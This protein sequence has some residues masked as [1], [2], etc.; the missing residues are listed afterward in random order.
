MPRD[1]ATTDP[2]ADDSIALPVAYRPSE[3]ADSSE[4]DSPHQAPAPTK[5]FSQ[6]ASQFVST[7]GVAFAIV[8]LQMGQGILLARLL[9]PVGRGEYATAVFYVQLL[10]YIG[11]FG[12]LEIICRYAAEAEL[13]TTRLRRAA[14]KLGLATGAITTIVAIVFCLVALPADK[15][16]LIPLA[17]LCSLSLAGQQVMLIM[18]AVDRGLGRFGTYN[19]RRVIAAA[20]FPVLLLVAQL[21]WGVTLE[22]ACGLFVIASL[23]SMGAC[24]VGLE[25]PFT[26]ESG[27]PVGKL[28]RESLPYALSMLATDLF[29][30]L[31][32]LLVLWIA[33]FQD[34]GFYAAMVPAVYPLTVLPNTMGIFLFNAAADR[35]RRLTTKDVHRILGSSIAVQTICTIVFLLLIGELVNLLYGAAFAPA[36]QFARWLAPV[37]AIK[38]ILQGL[39]SYVKGRGKPLVAIRCRIAAAALMIAVTWLLYDEWGALSVAIGALAGQVLCLIWLSAIVYADVSGQ[40]PQSPEDADDDD[41]PIS[42]AS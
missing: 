15:R 8:G 5:S 33:S 42:T 40:D 27:P 25:R 28:F 41:A 6:L 9:G 16:Y 1:S 37:A 35:K 4:D 17:I 20:A 32:L 18:T 13:N 34:Q 14:L 36:V 2:P 21:A 7:A 12:G 24:I 30:R 10:L 19:V 31:D 3:A 22:I 26:G 11:L 38:G 39:D 23:I 29:E